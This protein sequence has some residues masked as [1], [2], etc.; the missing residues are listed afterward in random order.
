MRRDW[1]ATG[2]KANLARGCRVC[3][4]N[5]GLERAHVIGRTRDQIIGRTRHVAAED[6]VMLCTRCH[7]TYDAGRL[8]LY[9]H[10]DDAEKAAAVTRAGSAGLALRR[11]SA[12]LWR[13]GGPLYARILDV[14]AHELEDL[15]GR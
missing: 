11:I 2:K 4:V 8:D 10:L 13:L 5:R 1:S 9:N 3:G 15:H 7:R 6:V 14:R 12:P